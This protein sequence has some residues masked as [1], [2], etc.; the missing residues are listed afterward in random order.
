MPG[1][2]RRIAVEEAFSIPEVAKELQKVARGPGES[3]DLQL[4]KGI[5][6]SNGGYAQMRFLDGLLDVEDKRLREMDE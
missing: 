2:F 4:V 6:D 5:Y 3:L 1:K